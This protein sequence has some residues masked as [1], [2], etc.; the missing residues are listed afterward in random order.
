MEEK[1][2]IVLRILHEVA[3][4]LV[5]RRDRL[6]GGALG[7]EQRLAEHALHLLGGRT[8]GFERSDLLLKLP[9]A[10]VYPLEGDGRSLEELFDLFGP[11]TP[12]GL[13]QLG[14]PEIMRGH[15]HASIL[16]IT[17]PMRVDP[18]TVRGQQPIAP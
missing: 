18:A 17:H 11:V 2:R 13:P 16:T 1:H 4:P 5:G 7:E 12:E 15:V 14:V 6:V 3:G 9:V 10:L 8:L